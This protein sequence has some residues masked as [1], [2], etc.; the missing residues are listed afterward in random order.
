MASESAPSNRTANRKALLLGMAALV[1]GAFATGCSD[2]A[3]ALASVD[4]SEEQ[5]QPAATTPSSGSSNGTTT[6]GGTSLDSGA[7]DSGSSLPTVDAGAPTSDAGDAATTTDGGAGTGVVVTQDVLPMTL[8]EALSAAVEGNDLVIRAASTNPVRQLVIKVPNRTGS[9]EC[10][11]VGTSID[12][13]TDKT[14]YSDNFLVG[15][16]CVV[17]VTS[18]G[19]VGQPVVGTFTGNV[20]KFLGL[21]EGAD[22]I[23]LANGSFSIVRT[24]DG[25]AR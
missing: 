10:K 11:S 17:N 14:N 25:P 15:R 8:K 9:S 1:V 23:A 5:G 3:T 19:A 4:D 13:K 7:I 22:K 6:S 20:A 18:L 21:G 2:G 16:D 12:W 24:A